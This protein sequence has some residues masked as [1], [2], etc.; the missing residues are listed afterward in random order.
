MAKVGIFITPRGARRL[1]GE[2]S[3][4][5]ICAAHLGQCYALFGVP[6]WP[7]IVLFYLLFEVPQQKGQISGLL[8]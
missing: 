4:P 2:P 1:D 7:M 6:P 8:I 3:G 5:G